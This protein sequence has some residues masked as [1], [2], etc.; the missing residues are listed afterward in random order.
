MSDEAERARALVRPFVA[1]FYEISRADPALGPLFE[2][3]IHD[4]AGHM[5]IV[6]DFWVTALLGVPL[7]GGTA[8]GAHVGLPVEEHHFPRWLAAL[9]QAGSETLPPEL[10]ERAMARARHMAMSFKAGLLPFRRADGSW[11]RTPG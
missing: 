5:E 10:A 7:Y 4:W 8:Y 1:R 11:G 6:V 3:A 2:A 9:E